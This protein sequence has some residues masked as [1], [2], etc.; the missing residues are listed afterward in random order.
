MRKCF[1]IAAVVL[2]II[3]VFMVSKAKLKTNKFSVQK[4]EKKHQPYD[5]FF[6]SRNYPDYKMDVKAYKQSVNTIANTIRNNKGLDEIPTWLLEGPTNTG[7]RINKVVV[8]PTNSS[9][10]YV[11]NAQGGVYKT[12][13]GGTIWFPIFDE[14]PYLSIGDIIFD[15]NNPDILYV[16]TGDPNISGHPSIGNGIYRSIDAGVTWTNL[17][18]TDK[19]IISKIKIDLTN[20]DIIYVA[21]MGIPFEMDNN[22]GLYKSIDAGETWTNVL[23]LTEQA[24]I[25]DLV[26]DKDNPQILYAAG[27]DRIRN[28]NESIVSGP[29]SKLYKTTD[30]G[31]TWNTL[32]TD[33]PNIEAT[34]IGLCQSQTNPNTLFT[35]YVNPDDFQVLGIYK[36][37]N[38]G[39]NWTALST[40]GLESALGGFGWYFGQIRVNPTN[41]NELYV[42]GVNLYKSVD[43]GANWFMAGPPW[44]T[45]EF[46]ADKHDI[47]FVDANTLICATDGGLY[48]STD[49]G[50]SWIDIDN[51]PNNQFYRIAVDPHNEGYYCGGV[52]DNGTNWGNHDTMDNWIKLLGGDGFQPIYNPNNPNLMYAETQNG[53]LYYSDSGG[54]WFNSFTDGINS[55]DRRSWDMPIIMSKHNSDIMFTGTYRVYK[56]VAAPYGSWNAISP[57]LTKGI[58]DKFHVITTV[59]QSAINENYLYAGTSDGIVQRSIDGGNNWTDVS[60]DL[61]NRYVTMLK[62][63]PTLEN[64]VYVSCS[65]YK[66]NDNIPHIHK[67]TN[68][69]TSWIDISGDLPQLAVNDILILEGTNDEHIFVGTDGGVYYTLDSGANWQR[70]G[71]G[72]PIVSVYDIEYD[73]VNK[74]LIA[75]TFARS[76]MSLDIDALINNTNID[77]EILSSSMIK[78]YPNPATDYI[79]VYNVSDK[80]YTIVDVYGKIVKSGNYTDKLNVSNLKNGYYFIKIDDKLLKFIKK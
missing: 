47:T 39:A 31:A 63:S 4:I 55:E 53:S 33:L 62:A 54:D 66:D 71:V 11:G 48:K 56:N 21:T 1:L 51:I 22:R 19:G 28:N 6:F 32:V 15:P 46:H 3:V 7:G 5:Y 17:G 59:E 34:R 67:S 30:G 2:S 78:V 44:Y 41:D 70:A 77:S 43:G 80:S 16:G 58:D 12:T 29:S 57:D 23:F 72:M 76:M 8:H 49:T 36:T 50:S 60:T 9:I 61:P 25:I 79:S 38:A 65:G 64:T 18:L 20:T 13:D 68:N 74:K 35:I 24:G 14:F 26:M 69:G 75:G 45:Y 37:T 10:M 73:A 52:Q 42:L 40:N 27:W